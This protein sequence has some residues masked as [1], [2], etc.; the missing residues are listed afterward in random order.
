[1]LILL[2]VKPVFNALCVE[3]V[4]AAALQLTHVTLIHELLH[5]DG[6]LVCLPRFFVGFVVPVFLQVLHHLRDYCLLGS[7]DLKTHF[8]VDLVSRTHFI[9]DLVFM[10]GHV[11][12]STGFDK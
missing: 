10:D 8:I 5:T 1:M 9:V 7:E 3:Y 12:S 4:R 6:A 11:V 2:L